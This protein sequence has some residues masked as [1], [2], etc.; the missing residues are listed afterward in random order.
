MKHPHYFIA[1]K[2][3]KEVKYKLYNCCEKLKKQ[4]SFSKWV[5]MED[6]HLTLA[7]LGALSNDQLTLTCEYVEAATKAEE[8]FTLAV[9]KMGIFGNVQAPRVFWADVE[10]EKK[11]FI[12]HYRKKYITHV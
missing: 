1:L 11:R 9:N 6:Y 4:F 5:H 8:S 3:P 2:L 7:F 12:F 10:K